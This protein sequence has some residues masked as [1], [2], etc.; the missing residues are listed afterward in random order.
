[1]K[2]NTLKAI[3][4]IKN[5]N[6]NDFED[7]YPRNNKIST[8]NRINSVGDSLE[9]F[10]KDAYSNGF[11]IIDKDEI[12]EKYFSFF[13][14]KNHPP[15]AIV[16][17]SDAI[18]VKKTGSF[19]GDIQ[20]NSSYPKSKLF[21]DNPLI[22]NACRLCEDNWI[23]KDMVYVLGVM[24]GKILVSI[25]FIYG[26]CF[27]AE[28]RIYEDLKDSITDYLESSDNTSE[29]SKTNEIGR[30]NNV[31]PLKITNLRIRGMWL[32]K[33]P[34]HIFN[35]YLQKDNNSNFTVCSI[36]L[37]NKF[38]SFPDE[39]KKIIIDDEDI[40]YKEIRIKNPDNPAQF[41]DAVLIRYDRI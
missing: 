36:I 30:L 7:I 41:L 21:A 3:I 27:A 23:E 35:D 8:K 32:L 26:D 5:F 1:M 14:S 40:K 25:L 11:K 39:D 38:D 17:H 22:T 20:L 29:F 18:E 28:A 4:N 31:D 37:K 12:Y 19:S 16:K 34:Y 15:D 2:T 24:R 10:V 33:N 9:F 13:G 6:K